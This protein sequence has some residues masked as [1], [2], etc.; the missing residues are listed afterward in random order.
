[1]I[2][3]VSGML[4]VDPTL[5]LREEVLVGLQGSFSFTGVFSLGL[6]LV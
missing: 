2:G 4:A 5:V 1:V 3:S 6:Q